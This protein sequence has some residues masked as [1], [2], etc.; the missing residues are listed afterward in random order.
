[1]PAAFAAFVAVVEAQSDAERSSTVI[2]RAAVALGGREALARLDRWVVSGRGRENLGAEW[3]GRDTREPTWREHQETVAI[4]GDAVAWERRTPRNDLS[5]RW[6]RFIYGADASGFVDWNAGRGRLSPPGTPLADR[7]AIARRIPHVLLRELAQSAGAVRWI[8]ERQLEGRV[9]DVID[10]RLPDATTVRVFIARSSS[11][12]GRLE[13]DVFMPGLGDAVISWTWSGWTPDRA[14][15]LKPARHIVS[16]GDTVYQQVD[17]SRYE[18]GAADAP[19]FVQLPGDLK[20]AQMSMAA[21]P[22]AVPPATGEVAPGIHVRTV[23]GFNVAAIVGRDSVIAIETPEAARGLEAI[24][25]SNTA[26]AGRVAPEQLAWLDEAFPGKPIRFLIISHHHGDHIG[27]APLLA[28]RGATVITSSADEA[29]ARHALGAS[30]RL[31]P[32]PQAPG[33]GTPRVDAV[34]NRRVINDGV[35]DIE[36][37]STGDNPHTSDNLFVWLPAERILFQGDLFYFDEG[38]AFPPSGRETMNRFFAQFLEARGIRP[39]AIYGVH[40]L[41]AA[42]PEA[43]AR[44]K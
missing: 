44:M 3:Q 21:P 23:Q 12:L 33:T 29:A 31:A 40:N 4:A 34:R 18:A 1:L 37:I 9:H 38:G 8:G 39:R 19:S 2:D 43:L 25:A 14:L 26:R 42:G 16:V 28:S 15:G 24:P 5:L 17:L 11:T 20:A 41:G 7:Q 27:G 13:Y 32:W 6:R 30:R 35:R 22:A 10:A 36:I